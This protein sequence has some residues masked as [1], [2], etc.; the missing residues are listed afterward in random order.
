MIYDGLIDEIKKDEG[1][2][3][4][5]YEDTRGY[6]TIGYGTKL[7]IDEI[8]A[9]LL[10][11]KRL[12]DTL[13]DIRRNV[14]F[15]E[16]LPEEA[17]KIL[18]NMGYNMGVPK[19]MGFKKMWAALEKRDFKEAAKEMRDSLWYNQVGDRAKRL[20]QRMEALSSSI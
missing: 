10:L 12:H 8:E 14:N 2:E 1:F 18:L 7:P 15:Y 13:T 20:A 4:I 6:P 5:P 3:P 9:T 19:L 17:Q 16:D 11:E